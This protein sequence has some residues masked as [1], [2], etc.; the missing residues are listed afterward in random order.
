MQK[1][2]VNLIPVLLVEAANQKVRNQFIEE[3]RTR[4]AYKEYLDILELEKIEAE[5]ITNFFWSNFYGKWMLRW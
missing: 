5:D 3:T 1:I 2:N 4:E